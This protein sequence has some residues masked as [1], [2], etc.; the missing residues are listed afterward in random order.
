MYGTVVVDVEGPDYQVEQHR[1]KRSKYELSMDW[2]FI[3]GETGSHHLHAKRMVLGI[4][5]HPE[6]EVE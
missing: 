4:H 2:V 6:R 5:F 1:Y 3:Y